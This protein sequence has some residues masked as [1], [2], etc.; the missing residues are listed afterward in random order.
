MKVYIVVIGERNEG[1]SV[2]R[3]FH[4]KEKA[5]QAAVEYHA[6]FSGGWKED[7]LN[8]DYWEN[9]CDFVSVTEYEVE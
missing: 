5:R 3:V 6:C 8:G 1:G 2:E 9:G 4:S 7:T